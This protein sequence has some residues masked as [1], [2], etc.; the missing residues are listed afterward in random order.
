MITKD[1]LKRFHT[2][3]RAV[4][5]DGPDCFFSLAGK[6]GVDIAGALTVFF[7]RRCHGA[8]AT[9]E[10]FTKEETVNQILKAKHILVN[11]FSDPQVYPGRLVKVRG[12]M[13]KIIEMR[14]DAGGVRYDI[15][16]DG[17]AETHKHQIQR[18]EME[19]A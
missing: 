13:A 6:Y 19:L 17:D 16:F 18:D 12:R 5:L 9:L 7:L 3:S 4:E 15:R 8:G 10:P 1:A 14:W 11:G 2:A